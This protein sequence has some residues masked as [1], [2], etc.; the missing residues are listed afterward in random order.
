MT[1][2]DPGSRPKH[3]L[4]DAEPQ[5]RATHDALPAIAT[6]LAMAQVRDGQERAADTDSGQ[7]MRRP[8]QDVP[9]GT[10]RARRR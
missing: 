7:A 3:E 10:A 5:G 2:G 4:D 6:R 9:D 8:G 1:L